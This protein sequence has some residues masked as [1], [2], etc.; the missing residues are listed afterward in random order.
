VG[1]WPQ[2]AEVVELHPGKGRGDLVVFAEPVRVLSGV[3]SGRVDA[4]VSC[5]RLR[6]DGLGSL[7][8]SSC[9]Q[10]MEKVASHQGK[11][12]W[13][14]HRWAAGHVVSALL[15]NML[16]LRWFQL[17]G[18]RKAALWRRVGHQ[19][20]CFRVSLYPFYTAPGVR[21][22]AVDSSLEAAVAGAM[23]SRCQHP[24]LL[25]FSASF[26]REGAGARQRWRSLLI[27]MRRLQLAGGF[28]RERRGAC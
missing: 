8:L 12:G 2:Y 16:L 26:L 18:T 24:L 25:T 21:V 13:F 1:R 10:S 14:F 5:V 28:S 4:V 7:G 27:L 3:L 22:A 15:F 17:A 11:G 9:K 19:Q 6:G 23:G 20:A